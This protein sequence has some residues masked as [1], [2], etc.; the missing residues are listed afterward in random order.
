MLKFLKKYRKR[1]LQLSIAVIVSAI[2]VMPNYA[3]E[4]LIDVRTPEEYQMSH[5]DGAI[6]L[7]HNDIISLVEKN[8]ISK[9]DSIKLYS[10]TGNRAELA[11]TALQSVGYRNVE[12]HK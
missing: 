2:F 3:K 12:I 11:K 5:P 1:I 7:P 6:N 9:H 8:N 10:R 4:V